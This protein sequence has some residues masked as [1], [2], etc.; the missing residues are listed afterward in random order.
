MRNGNDMWKQNELHQRRLTPPVPVKD[1]L[2]VGDFEGYMHVLSQDDGSLLAR[3]ELDGSP[4]EATP[5]VFEDIVY[6]YTTGG[7]LAALSLE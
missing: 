1:K 3:V 4:I 2:V 7:N 6:V 5:V